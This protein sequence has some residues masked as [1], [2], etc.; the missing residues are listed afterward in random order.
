MA[1]FRNAYDTHSEASG[2]GSPEP[3][4]IAMQMGAIT[5]KQRRQKSHKESRHHPRRSIQFRRWSQSLSAPRKTQEKEAREKCLSSK[6][7]TSYCFIAR[8]SRRKMLRRISQRVSRL[9]QN[10]PKHFPVPIYFSL[11]RK[12]ERGG[13][14]VRKPCK[15]WPKLAFVYGCDREVRA[16][17]LLISPIAGRAVRVR[18]GSL[19]YSLSFV[20]KA[21]RER[22]SKDLKT[23]GSQPRLDAA[24]WGIGTCLRGNYV[25]RGSQ[26]WRC[27]GCPMYIHQ[28]DLCLF[29]K[30]GLESRASRRMLRRDRS[31]L[32]AL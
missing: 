30:G 26:Q 18:L 25:R 29:S 24:G 23:K 32:L 4:I 16:N 8:S 15:H 9:R 5:P 1:R 28:G 12:W 20:F 6:L 31:R 17:S 11:L 10:S 13:E 14:M 7:A 19:P 21:L 2:T 3:L 27:R 22:H